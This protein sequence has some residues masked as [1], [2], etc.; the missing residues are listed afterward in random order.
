VRAATRSEI[1]R[2][3]ELVVANPDGGHILQTR[4]WGEFKHAWGWRPSYWMAAAGGRD[5]A[6][7]FLRRRVP[8]FGELW[9]APKGPGATDEGALVELLSDRDAMNNAFL[10]K[11]EPEIEEARANTG[12]WRAAGLRKAPNDVQMSRATIIVNLDRD[13]EA[14]LASFK[15]KTR[16][17]IRLAGRHGVEVAPA[18]MTDANIATMY[19]LM[20]ATRE[21]AGFFLRSEKYFRGY[22]ELQAASGQ[23]QLFFASWQGQV[24]AGVF[25][26][27]L[28][29]HGWYKDGGSTKEH[30]ELMAPHLLQWEVMR[31]L[32]AR[33]VKTYDLVA[34]PPA[35]QLNESHPL[36]GLYR[37]KSGFGEQITEFVGTWDLP[38][39]PRANTAWERWGERAANTLNRRLRHDLLY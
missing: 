15:S 22:W 6:I 31:W 16:Y 17:N 5:I 1:G 34:V 13:E 26:T 9:Y 23:A 20:A 11:V 32:R 33:G 27:F 18:E 4:G 30:S 25:A 35:S 38:L 7:L 14:L 37:F 36:F 10:V 21:R 2:W 39:R 3:D 28:G 29:T 12:E 19:S 8:G 24:L